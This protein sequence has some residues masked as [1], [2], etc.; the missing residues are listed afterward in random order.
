MIASRDTLLR[1]LHEDRD[2]RPP[3]CLR[4]RRRVH[5]TPFLLGHSLGQT[6]VD[7]GGEAIRSLGTSSRYSPW[8]ATSKPSPVDAA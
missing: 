5:G 6:L 4:E 2:F 3:L 1:C 8:N 7:L